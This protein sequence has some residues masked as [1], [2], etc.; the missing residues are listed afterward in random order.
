LRLG[1]W[2]IGG[3]EYQATESTRFE[4]EHNQFAPGAC[5]KAKYVVLN[6]VK[7]LTKVEAEDAYKCQQTGGSDD[8]FKAYG[9]IEAFPGAGTLGSLVGPWQISGVIY[10]TDSNTYFEQEH[11]FFALGAFVEVKYIISGTI[12]IA[13]KIETHVAPY[14]GTG[15][16]MGTLTGMGD[17]NGD[18]W[19]DW[20]MDGSNVI[21]TD[22]VIEFGSSG[23]PTI[24]DRVLLN[25]YRGVD[26]RLYAT[27]AGVVRNVFMPIILRSAR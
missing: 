9:A 14:G 25:T 22:H 13:T 17:D 26:G 15:T 6:G 3:Q 23:Q 16:F 19:P 12:N 20:E 27:T 4:D 2:V 10:Q 5:V 8:E 24:G 21:L 1:T 7:Y 11:G 18:G